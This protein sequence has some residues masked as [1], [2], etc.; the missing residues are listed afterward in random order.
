M[1]PVYTAAAAANN[2]NIQSPSDFWLFVVY[3]LVVIIVVI[4]FLFYFN[5][6]LG[7][8]LT[9]L[10]NQY[11]WR[12]HNAYVEVDS[13]RV[14][15]L[16]GRVLFK[17]L[18]YLSTNQSISI[19]KG[20][21]SI[22]YWLLNVRKSNDDIKGK[23]SDL[24]CRVACQLE[25]VECFIY[26]NVPA[27]DRMKSTFGLDPVDTR[28][29][30]STEQKKL[31]VDHETPITESI[32]GDANSLF[33]RLMPIQFEC[34]TSAVMIGN[35]ELK[36]MI[37]CKASQANG[38]Y[39]I[40]KS[41]SPM[42]H[43]KSVIDI[44]L[45]RC[46]MN[47]KDNMDYAGP[48]ADT[49]STR[50]PIPRKSYFS[51]L[52]KLT[53]W[54]LSFIKTRQYG[55]MQHM[56]HLMR[57]ANSQSNQ[58]SADDTTYH[59]EYARVNS[60]L[61]CN[62]M[63]LTYYA[64]YPGPTP[65]LDS[66]DDNCIGIIGVDVGNGGLPPE[67]GLRIYL[68]DAVV[69]YGPWADRQRN[70]MQEYFFP[71]AHRPN[72][73]TQR[74]APG[75]QRIPTCFET[76]IE[77]MNEGKLR[78]PT[79]E[80]SK[81]WKYAPGSSEPDIGSDGYYVR[82]YGWMDVKMGKGSHIKITTPFVYD[83]EGCI[84]KVD[85]GLKEVD[86]NTSVNYSSFI[87]SPRVK[88]QIE[89]PA[90][91]QWNGDRTWKINIAPKKPTIFLLRDHIYLLQDIAK[92]WTSNPP[93]DLLYFT[94]ITY[95]INFSS[96]SPTIY[97][98]VNEHNVINNPNSIEDN[99]FLKVQAHKI[100][101]DVVMPLTEY[102]PDTTAIK[103]TVG[104][105]HGSA[106]LSL[107]T[108]HT[109][110]AFMRE[111]D[112]YTAVAA[113]IAIEGSYEFYST[114]D[115]ARH[116][117][118]CNLYIKI[119]GATVK[120]FGT[121]IRYL[122]LLKDNYFGAWNNFSTIDEYRKR[123]ANNEEWLEQKKRQIESKPLQDPFEAYVL[124]DLEDGVLLL[125]EN[126]YECSRYSQLEF[127]ELQLELRN[128]DVYMDMYLSISPITIS[129]DS[130]PNP[131]SKQG[132]FRIKNAR[133]PK[134]YLYIDGF[135]VHAHRLFGPLPDCATYL[136]HWDF[137]VGRIWGEIK[138]CF[139]LGL[140][141]FGQSF[142]YNLIDEDNAVPKE[143]ESS[144]LPDATFLKVHIDT[145][146][147]NLMSMNS[148]TN[149]SLGEGVLIEFDNLIN[150]KYSQRITIKIPI[151]LM[152][153][154][155]NPDQAR[156]DN[157]N[158]INDHNY[159]WAEVAK[160][161]L[162]LNITVF[163]HTSSWKKARDEQQNFIRTQDYPT[164]RC[165]RLY[166]EVDEASQSSRSSF[167]SSA[168]EHHVG[169]LYAPPFRPFMSGHV[170]DK[171]V[172]YDTRS[173]SSDIATPRQGRS[174]GYSNPSSMSSSHHNSAK[175][176]LAYSDSDDEI[177]SSIDLENIC[178]ERFSIHSSKS[179]DNE[180]FHTAKDSD[181]EDGE[182]AV[183]DGFWFPDDY[184][185][186]SRE[187]SGITSDEELASPDNQFNKNESSKELKSAIPPSIPYSDYL[188]SYKINRVGN[189]K[190]FGSFFH[191]YV[192]PSQ[193][194]FVPE[195]AYEEKG[196]PLYDHN[197]DRHEEYFS[198][199]NVFDEPQ[200]T[201]DEYSEGNEVTA[202]TVIEATRP[203]SI[204]LTPI[205][206]KI[207][208][209]LAEEITKDDW[210]LETMLD[211]IQIQY[212]EQ[213]TR[214]LTD[215]YICT[216][217]AVILPQTYL[218]FIQN[219]TVPDDLPS[220]LH[221][222]SVVKTQYN[223]ED[224][225]LCSADV[226]MNEFHMI[227]SVKFED[228]AFAEKKNKVAE[229]NIVLQE[230][231]VHI[232]VGD[233]GSTVQYI[234]KQHERQSIAFGIPYES[235][236]NKNMYHY[237]EGDSVLVNEL[238]MLDLAI[239]GF[240]FKWL[241]ARTPNYADLTV[242][243]VDTIIITESVEI[244]V[245]AV[246]SW[247]VFV[248][249]LKSILEKFQEQ[250][251]KQVQVF[252]NEIANFSVTQ[253]V[254]GDPVFLTT[255]TTM[256]RLGSRNFR[257]DVGWK[258]LARMRHC[259][260]SM[261]LSKREELQ[262]RLT[263]GGALQGIDS[264]TIFNNVVQTFSLW[265]NWEISYDDMLHCRLITQPFKHLLSQKDKNASKNI[266]SEVAKF[267]TSSSN[268]AKFKLVEFK[269]TIYEEEAAKYQEEENSISINSIEFLLECLFKSSLISTFAESRNVDGHHKLASEGYLDAI[270]KI[271]VGEVNI[272]T[273]PII[274]A[275]A[276]HMLLVQRAF[277]T[278]LDD[279]L[280][281][282]T[283]SSKQKNKSE[284]DFD[285]NVLLSKV[286]VV[287]QALV[288]VE[289]INIM[290]QAQELCMD[291]LVTGI[292]SSILFS[293]PKLAPLQLTSHVDK[294]SDT[295][296]GKRSSNR[297]SRKTNITEPRLILEAA[298]GIQ[299]VDIKFKE[300][301]RGKNIKAL[302]E[303]VLLGI[304]LE[305]ANVN[306][307]ISQITKP[308]KKTTKIDFSKNVLNVFSNIHKFHVHVPQSLLRLY[309][310][311][312]S[313]QAE[314]GRRYHFMIQNL[315]KEWEVQRKDI[316]DQSSVPSVVS[317]Q[318][319][320]SVVTKKLDIKLQFLLNEF[321][322]QAD[323][324]PSLSAEYRISDLFIIVNENHQ[325]ALPIRMYSFQLSKQA[326]LL[327]TKDLKNKPRSDNTGIFNLPGIRSTGSLR[328]EIVD[329]T[330]Q[331]NL[332]S[333]I[334][335]DHISMS[336]DV[337]LIDTILTAQSLVGNEISELIEVLS[338]SKRS[339]SKKPSESLDTDS[340]SKSTSREF[341]YTV[342]ISLDGLRISA[343][344][345][346]AIGIF[347]SKL[348]EASISND[349][350]FTNSTHNASNKLT[351]KLQAQHFSLS[352][353]H[354]TVN[355]TFIQANSAKY[356]SNTHRNCLA[357]I[358]LD[359]SVQNYVSIC[360]KEDCVKE[361]HAHIAEKNFEAMLIEF[362]RIQT[363]MQPIAL[364]K[365]A[366]M[367][368]Y[369]DTELSKKKMMKKDELDRLSTNTKL[370]V[371]S[372]TLKNEWPNTL[373]N[374]SHSILEG[375][376]I[377]LSV[378]RLG[379][380]VPLDERS[381]IPISEECEDM[382]ALLLSVSSIE[383]FSKSIEKG[384]L[385]LEN[386]TIQFLKQFDQSKAEHFLAENHPRTNL[387]NFPLIACSV[388]ATNVKPIQTVDIDAKV[389]GFEMDV[390]GTIADYVNTLS[391]IYVKSMDRVNTFTEQAS[392]NLKSNNNK[393]SA[394]LVTLPQSSSAESEVVHLDVKAKFN[395]DSGIIRM[396][397][398]QHSGGA[399]A[400]KNDIKPIRIRTG[401]ESKASETNM[402]TV[403][404]P[405]LDAWMVYQTPLGAHATILDAP[406]QFHADILIRESR[407]TLQPTFVQFLREVT[408]GLKLGI[409][410]SS[411]RRADREALSET[412]S[413]MDAS[414]LLRLS[415]T[416][417]ELS[418]QP[419]SKVVC[420]VGW[421]A[422]EFLLNSFSKDTTSRT[423]SCMGSLR[424]MTAV[425]K[426]H[427]SPEACLNACIDQI[428]FSTMLTS[429]RKNGYLE[430]DISIVIDFPYL[431]ADLNMRHLQDLLILY[432]CWF[433]QPV[434]LQ[435][436]NK[437]D[438]YDRCDQ[439]SSNN[440][441]DSLVQTPSI[442]NQTDSS[443]PKSPTPFSKHVAIRLQ[444]MA[445]SV[446]LG[447][448][449]GK[450]TL[451]PNELSFQVHEAPRESKGLSV[452]LKTVDITSEGR[453]SGNA[454]FKPIS[455]LGR[456]D[457]SENAKGVA[458]SSVHAVIEGFEASFEYEYQNILHAIQQHLEL[459][460]A[461]KHVDNKFELQSGINLEAFIAR[462]SVKTVPVII[463]MAQR[464]DEL[465]QKKKLEAGITSRIEQS[466]APKKQSK[467][468]KVVVEKSQYEE[469]QV[470]SNVVVSVQ[471]IEFVIYPSQFQ[472]SDNVDIRAREFKINLEEFPPTIE[473]IRRKLTVTLASASLAKNVPGKDLM[474]RYSA[475]LPPAATKP[476][477][478]GGTKI[479]GIPGTQVDMNSLQ[480]DRNI[481]H[482][483]DA[484]FAGRIGVSLNI[485]LIK[486]LQEMINMFNLQLN[487]VLDRSYDRLQMPS[488]ISTPISISSNVEEHE[489]G[490]LSASVSSRRKSLFTPSVPH[491]ITSKSDIDNSVPELAVETASQTNE[492]TKEKAEKTEKPEEFTYTTS[493]S[494][495][496][497]P[498]LQVMGDATP[499]VEWL[500]LK[501]ER[502]PGMMHENV[503]LHLG[504]VSRVVWEILQS[505]MD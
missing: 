196:R 174:R 256:L 274:L 341:K 263:S 235:L 143:L 339:S 498:Q 253:A 488:D 136:C 352:L 416:Q 336:L 348:L 501:R 215:Q 257:N 1:N 296:S 353:D 431:S 337:G 430:D 173:L 454:Q 208:Q 217:F 126:I 77:F 189:D 489:D 452:I 51:A 92:D 385:H 129:R 264:A 8:I 24:P 426:H 266:T 436:L 380:A 482:Q 267:L 78:V 223:P 22:Q 493:G 6:V 42:D 153:C 216:R 289:S 372:I 294:D 441:L 354:N 300:E 278:K 285:F 273:N 192:P 342:D 437:I 317:S 318:P 145:I 356:K 412:E 135:N 401:F 249:D 474:L 53:D 505:Q 201:I 76:Y 344:S 52:M 486:Y 62:E 4:F 424:E 313:W 204:L 245:G 31:E 397:P 268:F 116:I 16:G 229:S 81:D 47:I 41:R 306:A 254:T 250:R 316:N 248:D 445:F 239:K 499:P 68:W 363:V 255:P 84:S 54:A 108:S 329:G 398:K 477:S 467:S 118:S 457:Q 377:C 103:F 376:A 165:I 212:V 295:G 475:P 236:R 112:A 282:P 495:N 102:Q 105:E 180:S 422:S 331:L 194:S 154:L 88:I 453:L 444:K 44:V 466:T 374:E 99:A 12:K 346:S 2:T 86:I 197:E 21:I 231:R 290:A 324:L 72:M 111:D 286:D 35:T 166:E 327:I 85:I 277:A 25:G 272:T 386:I 323:L 82:P 392:L 178:Y 90:P 451:S 55:G 333:I 405:G 114:V 150:V 369:Y 390:D 141:C 60:V 478:L 330:S 308:S 326:I 206:V 187:E 246:Y 107:Q 420:S 371:Q 125:P 389:K 159:S 449:I 20:H 440:Y 190:N 210:D 456:V 134:N 29:T 280:S 270:T 161:D 388:S 325:K 391:I 56:Q 334:S 381:D 297:G 269:F 491:D 261:P 322:I 3:C 43:Y 49:K 460:I 311:V 458:K 361:T 169:V 211:A 497:H 46:Q 292:Q 203:V 27:F 265:R 276:R 45:R 219:V 10:I 39:S 378:R 366:E 461:L 358:L 394:S 469:S 226:F 379:V 119:N 75:Q 221:G 281:E 359:F 309:G 355:D 476:K 122:F 472:D 384:A 473:G 302:S 156:V 370:I 462:I 407:N 110:N 240:S 450:I 109:L 364:G 242:Q 262:Y 243:S 37:V 357:Y 350:A 234:S 442:D 95:R 494:V 199:S 184:S 480:L 66:I 152:R 319:S 146:D 213:L 113:N 465:L 287:G 5:R 464:F 387:I 195:K 409:Q 176:E 335:V 349:C 183:F 305:R 71:N 343:S 479:F 144:S 320:V 414:L 93:V 439:Q 96:E 362:E 123:R 205:L 459:N 209:E 402:A 425:V 48:D 101:V 79:K 438:Q 314:Q 59:E 365:L 151:F 89:M 259:L 57:E 100:G 185:I 367:Y 504:K 40:V 164:R 496:F 443:S 427:F 200:E 147:I 127:Q 470:N 7:Q 395:C 18:R 167:H 252:I 307:N 455:I 421:Q 415:K 413:N 382:S 191:P 104:I 15:L 230:S 34:T 94:P 91:L 275:F 36:S 138:P 155:A 132:F 360:T 404:L 121:L 351:W 137:D 73:P 502:I 218:H 26:N 139:L 227:G 434:P 483:F 485:G 271:T 70:Q 428:S 260:R 293:N 133:D 149:I 492:D 238:V 193:T 463:T 301:M 418:C 283:Q 500:G 279:V 393:S 345:P 38:I 232:D 338:Y 140:A 11:T 115:I 198:R 207:I 186:V 410:Q 433:D 251:S 61:E 403:N 182:G 128:L 214:Y 14:S 9:F 97:L 224:T 19:I 80:K 157:L 481:S 130:N 228:Y 448:H 202:T 163:R 400:I 446:D 304:M 142:A 237:I 490:T 172:M 312:E 106:G 417:L 177:G 69:Q 67:W 162:G 373:Q 411:Q 124:L 468:T 87:Q 310:F 328:S 288:N 406:K 503:T 64:D 158:E 247:L 258:L 233:M 432:A 13:I 32:G 30:V 50:K 171:S 396:Y 188:R 33:E 298:G 321:L 419:V 98:C 368:I 120:L 63:A 487:R 408:A 17:N 383:F 340:L 347:Q 148:A 429:Q 28:P 225:V 332:R 399:Q 299:A 375:K 160:V 284:T 175:S 65:S 83:T 58:K 117:E 315:V 220:Y 447:Q 303:T 241:G 179:R 435:T 471:A 168:N 423:M 291:T 484:V 74:L 23:S 170:E 181:Y 222:E 244:L 131:Q